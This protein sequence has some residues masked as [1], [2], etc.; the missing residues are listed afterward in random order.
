MNNW[1]KSRQDDKFK[2]KLMTVK[3]TMSKR[4]KLKRLNK[5]QNNL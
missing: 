5:F 4:K 3:S 2:R 1:D